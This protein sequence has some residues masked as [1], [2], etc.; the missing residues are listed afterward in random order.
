MAE[1]SPVIVFGAFDRHNFG[2]LLFAH[3]AAALLL[4]RAVVFAGLAE[5]DM[6]AWGGHRVA[7]IAD[8]AAAWGDR[9]AHV[10]H[11]GGEI[12]TTS[13]YEA[14]VMLLDPETAASVIARYDSDP[15]GRAAWA[16]SQLGLQQAIGYQVPKRLF[17]RP[18]RFLYTGVGGADLARLPAALQTEVLAGLKEAEHVTVRDRASLA[19]LETH[20]VPAGLVPDPAV[21]TA[22]LLGPRIEA[23]RSADAPWS[24]RKRFPRG[25]IAVQCSAA[26]ADDATLR[27]LA[28]QLDRITVATGLGIVLFRAGA[29]PWHDDLAVYRRLLGFM[30]T[31]PAQLFVSLNVWDICAL[32]AG[33]RAYVGSSLH[34][35]IVAEAW[36]VPGVNLIPPGPSGG[37]LAAYAETWSGDGS[38]VLTRVDEL[39]QHVMAAMAVDSE[40]RRR[41]ASNQAGL[42]QSASQAWLACLKD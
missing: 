8:L 42:A 2:D 3:I 23:Q 16:R 28:G 5:R 11:A 25:Y 35:R 31:R 15:G 20:G 9:P 39:G 38:S 27:D 34:G 19:F 41:H 21:L 18:G 29:A 12:L 1:P 26:F 6:T 22:K 17:R 40:Q 10:V 4:P 36:G 30:S 33:A 14:A 7:A 13:L 37:K 24:V 32:L